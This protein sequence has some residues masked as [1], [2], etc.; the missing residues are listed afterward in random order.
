LLGIN[1]DL[2]GR[3]LR[4]LALAMKQTDGIREEDLH[5]LTWVGYL[6]LNDPPAPGV[7]ATIRSFQEAGVRTVMLTGDQQLTAESV[8]RELGLLAA[9]E[10]VLDGREVDRLPDDALREEVGRSAVFSRVSPQAKLRIVTAY[11]ARG[12]I[13]AMLG[14]GVNDAAAL[15]KADIGVAMGIRGTDLAKEAADLILA[16]D[17][18]STIAAAIEQGRIIFD[19]IRKFVFYLFSCNLAE[20]LVMLGAGL[21]GFPA[22]LLPLQILWLNLVTDTFPAL[23]LALE[24]GEPEIMRQPPRDPRAEILHSGLMRATVGYGVLIAACALGAFA[25]GLSGAA[26]SPARASTLAFLTLA[27]A[28]I[29]HLGNARSAGPVLSLRRALS[30]PL[31]LGA[32]ALAVALQLFA[33]EYLPL[34]QLL[35]VRPPD[36]WDWI[37]VITLALVPAVAGQTAKAARAMRKEP[38]RCAAVPR[39]R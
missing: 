17:R 21:V 33:I 22:P 5:G 3:G 14:D 13:V 34:A 16:D 25:W 24:P 8:A 29:F 12:E 11:Q 31:A 36:L 7:Q 20:I 38:S 9:G 18:F 19:N 15:R 30:N 23:V 39:G 1:R 27:L 26:G 35:R 2:A 28:Q 4:V 10:L 6:G 37:V 32:V